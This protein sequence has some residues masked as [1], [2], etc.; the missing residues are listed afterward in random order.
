MDL[1]DFSDNLPII[2][3]IIVLIALQFIMRRRRPPD[4]DNISIVQNI[5]S[6]TSLN[7]RMVDIFSYS[8]PGRGFMITSWKLYGS[9]LDFL[10]SQ[11]QTAISDAYM[12]AEDCNQQIKSAKKFKSTSYLSSVDVGKLKDLFTDVQE[13]LEEW[14]SSKPEESVA[15]K[16]RGVFDDLIGR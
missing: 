4:A 3:S 11:L 7:L 13:G 15:P 16:K 5:L 10:D 9:K 6:E 12:L 2:I 14:L 1:G 8:K